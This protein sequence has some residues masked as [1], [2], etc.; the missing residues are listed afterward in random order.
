VWG[1]GKYGRIRT[2]SKILVKNLIVD[3]RRVALK[4]NMIK[5]TKKLAFRVCPTCGMFLQLGDGQGTCL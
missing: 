4:C 2:E 5:L 1:F 3:W